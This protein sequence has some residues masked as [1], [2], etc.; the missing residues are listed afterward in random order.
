MNR[1]ELRDV[2]EKRLVACDAVLAM[3]E[4]GSHAFARTD[5]FSDLDI[6]L[7]ARNDGVDEA[8]KAVDDA[9]ESI[10]GVNLRWV[11][12]T[13]I[14]KGMEQRVFQPRATN[15]WLQAD[16]GVFP[17]SVEFLYNE[18]ERHGK[19]TVLFDKVNRLTPPK[20]DHEKHVREMR[21]ALQQEVMKWRTH[22]GWFRKE[23]ARGRNVD[24]FGFYIGLSIRPLLAVLGMV[25]RP[26]R[27]DYGFRY[28]KEDMP[29]EAVA[30]LQRVLYIPDPELLEERFTEANAMFD[31]AVTE[32]ARR[33]IT[34]IDPKGLD[35]AL[36]A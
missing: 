21:E 4:A 9:F 30:R 23:L 14:F 34:P 6:G 32:L 17:E 28:V 31:E 24:A 18:I 15:R 7:L 16:V 12:T 26:D 33:G 8:W 19:A 11:L 3:W 35:V 13:H 1:I 2:L 25:H 27:W 5:E 20:W 10:G 22:Y 29:A 36:P